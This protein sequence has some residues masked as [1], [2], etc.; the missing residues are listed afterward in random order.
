MK[1]NNL[2]ELQ[3]LIQLCHRQGVTNIKIDNIE[4][5]LSP[6]KT[7][8]KAST[9]DLSDFPEANIKVPAYQMPTDLEEQTPIE[10]LELT[11]EQRLFYSVGVEA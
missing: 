10:P 7:K 1:I 8:P 2:K 11:D 4:L 6:I 5:V 3:K 9:I